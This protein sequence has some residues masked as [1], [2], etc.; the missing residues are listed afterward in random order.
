M[1]GS[2]LESLQGLVAD[3]ILGTTDGSEAAALI[4]GRDPASRL[5]LYR[6]Q[7]RSTWCAALSL[8]FPVVERLVGPS[9]FMGLA[10]AYGRRWPSEST[11]MSAFG[12]NFPQ[13]VREFVADGTP[14]YLADVAL[15]EWLVKSV[16]DAPAAPAPGPRSDLAAPS[17]PEELLRTRFLVNPACRWMSSPH[18]IVRIWHAH[19]R[20]SPVALAQ[21]MRDAERALISR[22][23]WQV[24]VSHLTSAELTLLDAL[25]RL[26]PVGEALDAALAVDA[27]FDLA[28]TL[29]DWLRRGVLL[30]PE[31]LSA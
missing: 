22:T 31:R 30:R 27:R 7:L 17:T 19:Q 6:R 16:R 1:N 20:N 12:R 8:T 25:A 4:Q 28:A 5:Q 3:A 29:V 2:A 10:D 11:D 23:D 18:S 13:F 14:A 24:E 21:A 9:A 15:L 26:Q